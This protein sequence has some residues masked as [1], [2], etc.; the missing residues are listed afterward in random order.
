MLQ[1]AY[2][3]PQYTAAAPSRVSRLPHSDTWGQTRK[4]KHSKKECPRV[5]IS[6]LS[7]QQHPPPKCPAPSQ[8]SLTL[9][10]GNTDKKEETAKR[11]VLVCLSPPSAATAS[12]T[13]PVPPHPDTR[14]LTCRLPPYVLQTPKQVPKSTRCLS[15]LPE[16]GNTHE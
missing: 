6:S 7:T 12:P 2:T 3:L 10:R 4:K 14:G 1:C 8:L 15:S 9:T 5:L 13:C 16:G 11:R